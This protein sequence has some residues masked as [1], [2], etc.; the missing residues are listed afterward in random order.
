VYI[1]MV[2]TAALFVALVLFSLR[3][4][5]QYVITASASLQYCHNL[6]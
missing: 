1:R 5:K 2:Y 4:E 6:Y 3:N